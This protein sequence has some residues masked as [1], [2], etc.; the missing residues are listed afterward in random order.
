MK[1][2]QVSQIEPTVEDVAWAREQV[3][4]GLDPT[5]REP[6]IR[7]AALLRARKRLRQEHDQSLPTIR[8]RPS[9][10]FAFV[11][12]RTLAER[13]FWSLTPGAQLTL[14]EWDDLAGTLEVRPGAGFA[15]PGVFEALVMNVLVSRWCRGARDAA[16]P[17]VLISV[18]EI[19]SSIGINDSGP[20]LARVVQAVECLKVTTYRYVEEDASGGSSDLFSLLDRVQTK[21]KGPRTSPHRRIRARLSQPVLDAVADRRMIRPVD[22]SALRDLGEQRELARRLFLFLEARPGHRE[23]AYD[24]IEHLI[25]GRLGHTLGTRLA[26]ADLRKKLLRAA[27]AIEGV[28]DGRYRIEIVPRQKAAE[29]PGEPRYLLRAL[30]RRPQARAEARHFTA[31]Q[32]KYADRVPSSVP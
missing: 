10:A 8:S 32:E 4:A 26:L 27:S 31:T 21:W 2:P 24:R 20:N 25:D 12:A 28:A 17:D 14:F 5:L 19:A 9:P 18:T 16:S 29:Y 22:I 11:T 23:G 13:G 1:P 30:R 3:T 15:T 6:A 7:V